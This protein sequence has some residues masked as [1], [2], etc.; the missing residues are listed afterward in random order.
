MFCAD[1]TVNPV[2]VDWNK[3]VAARLESIS[4]LNGGLQEM[5]G[6][7]NYRNWRL[8]ETYHPRAGSS[9]TNVEKGRWQLHSD[10]YALDGGIFDIPTHYNENLT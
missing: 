3:V 7:Q 10:F 5:N 6:F 8:M 9:W 4:G 2:M 1:L